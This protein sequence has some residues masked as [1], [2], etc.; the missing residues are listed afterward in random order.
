MKHQF[1]STSALAL[2][3]ILPRLSFG[4]LELA[5]C[6]LGDA[7]GT[8]AGYN[9]VP[10]FWPSYE[11]IHIGG[12]FLWSHECKVLEDGWWD[13]GWA[14][15]PWYNYQ[16]A[17]DD[18]SP[19]LYLDRLV[20]KMDTSRVTPSVLMTVKGWKAHNAADQVVHWSL[21]PGWDG[22]WNM[23]DWLAHRPYE[24][25]A[26][27]FVYVGVLYKGAWWDAF[28]QETGKAV[29]YPFTN[30]EC[31]DTA[32][33]AFLVLAQKV[34]RKK[35]ATIGAV[36]ADQ[37]AMASID[38]ESRETVTSLRMNHVANYL[39]PG[40][41]FDFT[42]DDWRMAQQNQWPWQRYDVIWTNYKEKYIEAYNTVKAAMGN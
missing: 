31:G 41:M 9:T 12:Y 1:L 27:M 6:A 40:K 20:Q 36:I 18:D 32:S 24:K 42:E 29:G 35:Q 23:M 5:H 30:M 22:H 14:Q 37:G 39:V 34:F 7:T 2:I 21:F 25:A 10:D 11:G 33:D 13:L 38:V 3:A 15:V 28:D 16:L 8:G 4:W 19:S 17:A 26:D